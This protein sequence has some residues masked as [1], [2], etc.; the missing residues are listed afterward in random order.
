M[1]TMQQRGCTPLISI[2]QPLG[3]G[4]SSTPSSVGPMTAPAAHPTSQKTSHFLSHV[5]HA[6]THTHTHTH[7]QRALRSGGTHLLKALSPGG[8]E[9]AGGAL[10]PVNVTAHLRTDCCGTGGDPYPSCRPCDPET[11]R[12]S[13]CRWSPSSWTC[14]PCW[15]VYP[16][17][18]PW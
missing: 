15:Q 16:R 11:P 14:S 12:S 5:I 17:C 4:F 8:E 1:V 2:T 7:T 9:D 18:S 3:G 6:H 13:G 10:S